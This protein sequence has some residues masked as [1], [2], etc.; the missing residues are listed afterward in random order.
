MRI[1]AE[2]L[3]GDTPVALPVISGARW[4]GPESRPFVLRVELPLTDEEIVALYGVVDPDEIGTDEGL[5]GS[6]AI[7]LLI[8]GLP[9]LEACTARLRKTEQS[10]AVESP[11]S[12]AVCRESYP[13]RGDELTT[14]P[15]ATASFDP[16]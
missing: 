8:E 14:S 13:P 9:A 5:C 1:S 6:V 10:C 7:A 2:Q 15:P 11:E 4:F 16:R 12:V 3:A